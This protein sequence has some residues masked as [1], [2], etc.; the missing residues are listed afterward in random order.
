MN[1]LAETAH[2]PDICLMLR[3]HAEQSLLISDIVPVVRQLEQPD[4]LAEHEIGPALSYLEVLWL[5]AGL[6]AV[7]TDAA[8]ER[9][10]ASED[11]ASHHLAEKAYRYHVA[12]KRLRLAL[13]RRV[14]RLTTPFEEEP[15]QEPAAS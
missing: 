15:A 11:F 13:G 2:P 10:E 5:E 9:L 1:Q 6:R 14:C 4:E 12:V 3:V 8:R 7:Q